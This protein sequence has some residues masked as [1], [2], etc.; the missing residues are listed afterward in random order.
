MIYFRVRN[1]EEF[2]HYKHRNP[3][4]IRLYERI[5]RDRKFYLLDEHSKYVIIGLFLL[6][7]QHENRVEFDEQWISDQLHLK[8]LPNWKTILESEFIQPIDCD[9][10]AMLA[11]CKRDASQSITDNSDSTE[12]EIL[13]FSKSTKRSEDAADIFNFWNQ[14]P[15]I[16]HHRELKSQERAI[17]KTLRRYDPEEIKT[18]I[19][20]YSIV[21]QNC[22][23]K[24]RDLYS[25]TLGEFLTRQEHYNIERF[26]SEEWEQP[27]LSSKPPGQEK[28]K[29]PQLASDE[30]KLNYNPCARG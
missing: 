19:H 20:R 4:W 9:A 11:A 16:V 2:Q 6:A 25:W 1:F 21:R 26:I 24:Y 5:L 27:F 14:Q 10:S 7:S 17:N 30:D 18:S 15:A 22:N 28:L 23:G 12:T 13:S 8:T 3:P 29:T